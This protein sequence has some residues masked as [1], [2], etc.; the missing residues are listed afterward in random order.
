MDQQL[1]ALPIMSI[2]NND[3][4]KHALLSD[5]ENKEQTTVK[6]KAIN[7]PTSFSD[8]IPYEQSI[9]SEDKLKEI[10]PFLSKYGMYIREIV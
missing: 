4:M 3:E 10:Y 6:V 2:N 1:I 5:D 8:M 7:E 9:F